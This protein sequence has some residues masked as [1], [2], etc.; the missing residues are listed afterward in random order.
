M[1][2]NN[3]STHKKYTVLIADDD[4]GVCKTLKEYLET[5]SDYEI[6]IALTGEDV[7]KKIMSKK[8]T[9]I[10]LDINMPTLNGVE[11]IKKIKKINMH[12]S[13]IVLTAY[14]NFPGLQEVLMYELCEFLVKPV[15]PERIKAI[16]DIS[17]SE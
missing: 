13:L 12:I 16:L 10:I 1:P 11:L 2:A 9:T 7:L 3:I 15:E 4:I 14:P 5:V 17:T 8:I 6:D